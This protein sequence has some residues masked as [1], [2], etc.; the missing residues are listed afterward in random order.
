MA[1]IVEE[2]DRLSPKELVEEHL[3]LAKI[4]AS[5]FRNKGLE[6][7]DLLQ[8]GYIG[9]IKAASKF[10]YAYEVKFSTYAN[11]WVKQTIFD[12]LTTKSRTIRL[13]NHIVALKLKV[14][15]FTENFL[16]ST[17]FEPDADIIAKELKVDKYQVEKV[18]DLT[19]EHTGA[20][21]VIE[22]ATTEDLIEHDDSIDHVVRAIRLLSPKEKLIMAMK[23]GLLKVI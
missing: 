3:Y 5:K 15:K 7:E 1:T 11:F 10:D 14:F 21:E 22:E 8:E 13:P 6:Y 23:F 19:T 2:K 18:M 4:F 20:W 16:L 12:A 9:L 17:G